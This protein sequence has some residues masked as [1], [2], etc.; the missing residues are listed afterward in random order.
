LIE[1]EPQWKFDTSNQ[2]TWNPECIP[3]S[4]PE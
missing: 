1:L 3:P 2:T 4:A